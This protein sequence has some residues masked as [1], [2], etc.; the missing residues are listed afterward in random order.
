M[1]CLWCFAALAA[2]C[3][4]ACVVSD[5]TIRKLLEVPRANVGY[6]K[7][8]FTF[9]FHIFP[10]QRHSGARIIPCHCI[11][12]KKKDSPCW[13]IYWQSKPSLKLLDCGRKIQNDVHINTYY[14]KPELIS[15]RW[16]SITVFNMHFLS[17][18]DQKCAE[19]STYWQFFY[20]RPT[21]KFRYAVGEIMKMWCQE[22]NIYLYLYIYI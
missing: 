8:F 4:L 19:L 11:S 2:R 14:C 5:C 10:E 15:W 3:V 7:I 20:H 6:V 21:G 13:P 1:F 12:I 9:D 16:I 22:F 18:T 17:P